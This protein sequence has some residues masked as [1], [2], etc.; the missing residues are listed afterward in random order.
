[1]FLQ[2]NIMAHRRNEVVRTF[3]SEN[4]DWSG[5]SFGISG[6][7]DRMPEPLIR[8]GG[9]LKQAAAIVNAEVVPSQI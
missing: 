7:T 6:L 8:A 3:A 9:T 1:M 4:L 2:T 5:I